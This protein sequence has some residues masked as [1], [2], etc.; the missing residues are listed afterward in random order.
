MRFVNVDTSRTNL[1]IVYSRRSE[2]L[3]PTRHLNSCVKFTLQKRDA[4]FRHYRRPSS[5]RNLVPRRL[6]HTVS[7]PGEASDR[8]QG[9]HSESEREVKRLRRASHDLQQHSPMLRRH[10]ARLRT[11]T[12]LPAEHLI[13]LR[14]NDRVTL[15]RTFSQRHGILDGDVSTP[16]AD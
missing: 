2:Q 3:S 1:P 9:P 12:P 4:H 15:A 13:K 10:S 14:L 16:V 11:F 6:P 7:P 8:Y 5:D